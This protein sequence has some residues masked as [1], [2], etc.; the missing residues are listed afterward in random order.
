MNQY[1]VAALACTILG[2][3]AQTILNIILKHRLDDLERRL[4]ATAVFYSRLAR[5]VSIK[6]AD[7]E[8]LKAKAEFEKELVN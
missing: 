3:I 1:L 4:N 8:I 7:E 2:L 5:F 6:Y